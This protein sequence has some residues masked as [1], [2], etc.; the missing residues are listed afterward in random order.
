MSSISVAH[1]TGRYRSAEA[2]SKK[3]TLNFAIFGEALQSNSTRNYLNWQA[4][5]TYIKVEG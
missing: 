3:G 2:L 1:Y 5:L 4:K